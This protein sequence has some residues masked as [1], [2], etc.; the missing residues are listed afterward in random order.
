M[1]SDTIHIG[2]ALLGEGLSHDDAHTLV[3]V[4]GSADKASSLELVKTE[5]DVFSACFSEVFGSGS[6]AVGAAIVLSETLSAD[7]ASHVKL[8]SNA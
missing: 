6:L 3:F 7:F 5:T 4:L 1:R 8:V 2:D